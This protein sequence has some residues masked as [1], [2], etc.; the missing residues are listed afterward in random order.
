MG[1]FETEAIVLRSYKLGEADKIVLALTRQA[2]VIR[3]VAKGARRLK[4]KFGASLE[5]FTLIQLSCFEK[6][7]SE[8]VAIRQTEIVT[9]YFDLARSDSVFVTM[10]YLAELLVEFAPPRAPDE[11]LFR[12]V[13]ACLDSLASSPGQASAV[14][15]YFEIWT[16]RLAGFL[17][18][19]KSCSSCGRKFSGRHGGA[20]LLYGAGLR[21]GDCSAKGEGIAL[22][23]EALRRLN[24]ALQ[25]P[26]ASWIA[27]GDIQTGGLQEELRRFLQILLSRAL[28]RTPRA[29]PGLRG[30]LSA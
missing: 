27:A 19:L 11:R 15:R 12:M 8:L 24:E 2:G 20:N 13:K 26:P 3:G 6:E 14:T 16:L 10:E 21:C 5:P 17:P 7:N 1:L 22:S 28:E 4:S 29:Q 30:I 18:D 9:S 23:A 25:Q